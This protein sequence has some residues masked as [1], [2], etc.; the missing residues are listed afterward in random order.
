MLVLSP[1]LSAS[2]SAKFSVAAPAA[3]MFSGIKKISVFAL[4]HN[5]RKPDND[6]TT[7]QLAVRA[8]EPEHD[9]PACR[10]VARTG[11]ENP[12]GSFGGEWLIAA[13][14]PRSIKD[15][16]PVQVT[17]APVYVPA[18][19]IWASAATKT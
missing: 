13:S 11:A 8:G 12:P 6:T 19:S 2:M 18:F 7:P 10:P 9:F 5:R 17:A 4:H 1:K 15:A 3:L 14:S 16:A